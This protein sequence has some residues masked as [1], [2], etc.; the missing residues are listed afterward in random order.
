MTGIEGDLHQ[1]GA[2]AKIDEDEPS[3]IPRAMNPA[4]EPDLLP[5]MLDAE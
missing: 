1:S 2:I 5:R 4:A 3:E